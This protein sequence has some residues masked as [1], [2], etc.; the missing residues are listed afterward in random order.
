MRAWLIFWWGFIFPKSFPR[1]AICTMWRRIST[2]GG[3]FPF[4][5]IPWKVN[6]SKRSSKR[7]IPNPNG[8]FSRDGTREIDIF[9]RLTL[10]LKD[11]TK[12]K[13]QWLLLFAGSVSLKN[14]TPLLLDRENKFSFIAMVFEGINQSQ[15]SIQTIQP[16]TILE[17]SKFQYFQ[18]FQSGIW[19]RWGVLFRSEIWVVSVNPDGRT[20]MICSVKRMAEVRKGVSSSKRQLQTLTSTFSS[21]FRK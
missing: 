11:N 14:S 1:E 20:D 19:I 7:E 9:A 10:P 3:R 6:P 8:S 4:G 2:H 17:T 12:L 13:L 21:L 18:D 16:I 15:D 5:G